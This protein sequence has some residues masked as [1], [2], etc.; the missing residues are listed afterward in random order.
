MTLNMHRSRQKVIFGSD[1]EHARCV[2][3]STCRAKSCG[4]SRH[5]IRRFSFLR[6]LVRLVNCQER[7]ADGLC[8]LMF[9]IWIFLFLVEPLRLQNWGYC[10]S[11][12]Q[13]DGTYG[14]KGYPVFQHI[15]GNITLGLFVLPLRWTITHSTGWYETH[16]DRGVWLQLLQC[17]FEH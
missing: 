7:P 2:L 14:E 4:R 1:C 15:M 17:S 16:A 9:K 3:S 6:Y 13:T 10:L 8:H 11:T 5:I 12:I